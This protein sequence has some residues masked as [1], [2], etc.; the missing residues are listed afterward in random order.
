MPRSGRTSAVKKNLK[1]WNAMRSLGLGLEDRRKEKDR[2]ERDKRD[3]TLAAAGLAESRMSSLTATPFGRPAAYSS[4]LF[5]I[6][7]FITS[8]PP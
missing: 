2:D 7:Q 5:I 8:S 3:C 4:I 6:A 1:D